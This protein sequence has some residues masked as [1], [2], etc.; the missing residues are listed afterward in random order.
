MRYFEDFIA[1][2]FISY[3]PIQN[4]DLPD[5]VGFQGSENVIATNP[6]LH[7]THHSQSKPLEWGLLITTRRLSLNISDD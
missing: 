1:L 2:P 3:P 7:F 6:R 4:R 5:I